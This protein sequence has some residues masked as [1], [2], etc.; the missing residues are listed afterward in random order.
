MDVMGE[1]VFMFVFVE[2]DVECDVV[3]EEIVM[4]DDVL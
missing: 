1:M 3:F 4:Y 2:F